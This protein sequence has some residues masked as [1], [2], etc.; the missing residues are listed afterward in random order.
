MAKYSNHEDITADIMIPDS[1]IDYEDNQWAR[2]MTRPAP[3]IS[4]FTD[5]SFV[6][7]C[8]PDNNISQ[9]YSDY[10]YNV[11]TCEPSQYL[12]KEKRKT[13][14]HF[15]Y[16]FMLGCCFSVLIILTVLLLWILVVNLLGVR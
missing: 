9:S 7:S 15:V 14:I 4:H 5:N 1:Y 11:S 13:E 8:A 6:V 3:P 12:I 16:L 2:D 10:I